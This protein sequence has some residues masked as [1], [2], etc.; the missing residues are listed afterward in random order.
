MND[1]IKIMFASEHI[2]TASVAAD[3]A[4]V[5]PSLPTKA[6]HAHIMY[7]GGLGGPP[8]RSAEGG[9]GSAA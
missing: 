2:C 4:C 3:F 8:T 1:S 7:S 6:T 9:P 5:R